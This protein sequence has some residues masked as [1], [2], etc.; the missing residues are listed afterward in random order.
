[1]P[2]AAL[3]TSPRSSVGSPLARYRTYRVMSERL[4]L[5]S[6]VGPVPVSLSPSPGQGLVL[7]TGFFRLDWT[8]RF[9]RT[10]VTIDGHRYQLPW[11]VHYF[12]LEP[13][14]HR[15]EVSYPYLRLSQ[16]GR[17]SIAVDV[18]PNQVVQASYGAPKSVLVA[19]RPG[20]LTVV[21]PVQS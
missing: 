5:V 10:T 20:K 14:C 1:M 12:P 11:G 13:G 16:A 15:L 18:A 6:D 17:A 4:G 19:F 7:R 21:P 3:T 2:S 9:T 8:L